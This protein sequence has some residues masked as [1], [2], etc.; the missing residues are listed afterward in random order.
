MNEEQVISKVSEK[1]TGKLFFK[2]EGKGVWITY[3]IV[4]GRFEIFNYRDEQR[5][6]EFRDDEIDSLKS[7]TG[8]LTT[9]TLEVVPDSHTLT[10]TLV[11]PEINRQRGQENPFST[12]KTSYHH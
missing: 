7:K 11:L 1:E 10:L 9:V 2:L 6:L 12:D 8:K 4:P 3:Q 5:A